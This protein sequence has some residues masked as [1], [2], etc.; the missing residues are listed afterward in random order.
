MST[1]TTLPI[2]VQRTLCQHLAHIAAFNL[3]VRRLRVFEAR[4]GQPGRYEW[5]YRLAHEPAALASVD[6]VAAIMRL[7][8]GRA[9]DWD[10]L[11][12]ALGYPE[13][14]VVPWSPEALTWRQ[15]RNHLQE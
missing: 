11:L 9:L 8:A 13:A 7:P 12:A 2:T 10:F 5:E 15:D 3:E 6:R 14:I 4:I 1:I